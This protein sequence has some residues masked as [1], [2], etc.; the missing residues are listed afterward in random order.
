MASCVSENGWAF[1]DRRED[2]ASFSIG[3]ARSALTPAIEWN[4]MK[5]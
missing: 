2:L 3:A 1:G 5:K 4:W